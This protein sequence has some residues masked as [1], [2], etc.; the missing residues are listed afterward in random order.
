MSM[1]ETTVRLARESI[2]LFEKEIP[3]VTEEAWEQAR[4]KAPLCLA[5]E[6]LLALGLSAFQFIRNFDE[7]WHLQVFQKKLPYDRET[8]LAIRTL[9]ELWHVT[10]QRVLETI[11]LFEK[12]GL[13]VDGAEDFKSYHREAEGILTP[14]AEFYAGAALV[15]LRDDAMDSHRRG[16]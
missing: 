13:E 10:G 6:G 16:E 9:Y 3:E 2:H 11:A 14:D 5:F 4:V 7:R 15:K 8:D 1:L 12:E